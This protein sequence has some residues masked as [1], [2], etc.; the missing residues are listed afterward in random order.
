MFKKFNLF[1][2]AL[3]IWS[4]FL[5]NLWVFAY[6]G[7]IDPSFDTGVP[8]GFD[9]TV[10]ALLVQ[11]DGKI[12]VW[13]TFDSYQWWAANKIIRLYS[14]GSR[15]TTFDIG[16]GFDDS[17]NTIAI[18]SDGKIIVG[19]WFTAY[20]WVAANR[21]IR[22]HSDGSRDM[23]FDISDGFDN[24]V[25]SMAIQSD[26]KLLVWWEFTTYQWIAA[27]NIIRLN[28]DG[29]RD[30]TFDIGDGFDNVVY[31]MAIQSDGK[32][33]VGGVFTTYQWIAANGIIRLNTDGSKD[34]TFDMG[35]GFDN[36]VYSIAI[37]SDGKIIVWVSFANYQW[38]PTNGMIRLNTD[39]SRDATF[40]IGDGFDDSV[41]TITIQ[42]DGKIIVWWYFTNYQWTETNGLIRLNT[43][44]SKDTAF[45]IGNGLID[46]YALA[47]NTHS[48]GK[49]IIAGDFIGY[50]WV[51]ANMII[52][53]NTD[54]SKD[55]AFDI[56]NGFGTPV[57]FLTT[58]TDQKIL[59]GGD[60][61]SYQWILTNGMIRL[62]ANGS[63]DASFDIG[64][65]FDSA[66]Y[67]IAIQSDGKILVW[68]GFDNYQW[69]AANRIIRLNADGSRD[70]S[71]DI[72][73]GFDDTIISIAIQ[74][75]GK[76]IVG[77]WFTTYQWIAANRIIRLNADGSRDASFDIGG[78]F[79]NLVGSIIIQSD[80]KILV[81]WD[82]TTYQW[83][84]ANRI[85]R[86]NVDGSRDASFDIGGGFNNLVGS[87]II[88][89]DEKILVWWGFTAYQWV[90]ANRIIRL[91]ADGSRD[92]SFDIGGGFNSSIYSINIQ[93]N[94][95][96]LAWWEFT[97]Y[98][99]IVADWIIRLNTNGSRDMTFDIGLGFDSAVYSIAIQS[100][101]KI[102]VWWWFSNYNNIPA[103]H[104]IALYWESPYVN[105]PNSSDPADTIQEFLAKWY[106]QL[107][108]NL[109]G[110]TPIFL[111][112]S[113]G[114]IPVETHI[115]ENNIKLSLPANLQLKRADN[116]THFTGIFSPPMTKSKSSI[117]DETI[118]SL[119]TIG[120][121]SESI[122]LGN[123]VATILVPTPGRSIG[124]IVNIYYSQNNGVN[125]NPHAAAIVFNNEGE[126][127]VSFITDH[128]TDFAVT[129]P[130]GTSNGSFVI[131]A[132]QNT[133]TSQ[134]I[135]LN[136]SFIPINP[137]QMRFSN[138][139]ISR[140]S[141]EAYANT[142]AWTL[143]TGYGIKT[144]Y[145]EFDMNGN[146]MVDIQTNTSIEYIYTNTS[147]DL[148]NGWG[149]SLQPD[150][151]PLDRDCSDSYYDS[152]CGPC[153]EDQKDKAEMVSC[154]IYTPE[155]NEAYI[156]GFSHNIT[157][158]ND[159]QRANL[160]WTLIRSH[161][162]KMI[163]NFALNVL[164]HQVNTGI[165]CEFTDISQESE[166]MQFFAKTS[167][168]LWLMWLYSDGTPNT[169]FDPKDIVT[170]AQFGTVL[171][172]LLRW[173]ENNLILWE[174]ISRY[175]KHLQALQSAGIMNKIN[176]HYNPELRWW[177]M[178]M[179]MRVAKK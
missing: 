130:G 15:D 90:A 120:S 177:V 151:C 143:S 4:G 167:C 97:T 17:V 52:R 166:E 172:R 171:S 48:D 81:W 9:N 45:D 71:F 10:N 33:I 55:T 24:V 122:R 69:V 142:K 163:S 59:I 132:W 53:L 154:N 170:R 60:L 63:R 43:D 111:W 37:Q 8:V 148:V 32:I 105:I 88:Q 139:G 7:Q 133:S 19:G 145:A 175:S 72:G 56:G 80:G 98:Q 54:G 160:T 119:F 39:G 123:W 46:W 101:G 126:S 138:N 121:T 35:M 116:I 74:S 141:R 135:T 25:Y 165:N 13:W 89:S 57:Y 174:N 131:N 144:V 155:L 95:K 42:S 114:L 85:I 108:G 92:A 79:N 134:N 179:L 21:I 20:Q 162:A 107:S 16:D 94:D 173:N 44:G 50:K 65:G 61:I 76:I 11:S 34:M 112:I 125:R 67:F 12:L 168:Q 128:F 83:V 41:N 161:M 38:V 36:A 159:C 68:W 18:Q 14:D 146:S 113:N 102:F 64:I 86:L 28:T 31:S 149:W 104:L 40:D 100:D 152:I 82:F 30:A 118:V 23:T 93:S 87:I 147:N 176:T 99:W 58:Q 29:S 110:S 78:G 91:N 77:G 150:I 62:N 153:D 124:D 5:S 27:N 158:I 3:L 106:T 178:L 164:G 127:Y 96:I 109:I 51:A 2:L 129:R 66:V 70:A 157:T 73:D 169:K 26:G 22:L 75:D 84:A 136:I 6:Q 117:I 49:I 140:S 47:S 156:F 115:K 137:Q 103:W 1:F